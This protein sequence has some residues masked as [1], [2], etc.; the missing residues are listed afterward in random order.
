M[1]TL[2]PT[3]HVF[4]IFSSMKNRAINPVIGSVIVIFILSI[5]H[6]KLTNPIL[7]AERFF[8]GYGGWVEIGVVAIYAGFII[9]RMIQSRNISY[10]RRLTWTLFTVIF[11][12]QLFLGLLGFER[13]LMTGALHLPIPA[14][15]AGGSLYK[16]KLGFMPVLFLSTIIISG[17]A[18]CSQLC[19]FGA[20]DLQAAKGGKKPKKLKHK[21][22]L[23]MTFLLLVVLGAIFLRLFN[24]DYVTATWMGGLFGIAGLGIIIF[25]SRKKK[26]MYHCTI[27]CPIGTLTQYLKS[28]NPFRMYIEPEACT[29]CMHCKPHCKYDAL[30]TIDIK[31]GKPGLSCTYC[32]DCVSSCDTSAIKYKV[33]NL[34]DRRAQHAW[35]V[36]S[37]ALHAVFLALG[38]I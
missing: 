2:L 1:L 35:I 13:F 19:Y 23:K 10:W 21:N 20:I 6:I 22:S 7:I 3:N 17:P 27:Y 8:P 5:V 34:S 11:F 32:G 26:M 28:I 36:V 37:I 25:I 9:D 12:S 30:H 18:W 31:S 14:M 16:L 15:I 33:F 38:R 24:I 4:T 29:L